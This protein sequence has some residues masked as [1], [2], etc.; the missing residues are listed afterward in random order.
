M[1][2][3]SWKI[4]PAQIFKVE[5]AVFTEVTS[6][7]VAALSSSAATCTGQLYGLEPKCQEFAHVERAGRT[8]EHNPLQ[9]QT[10][11]LIK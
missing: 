4:P 9:V 11:S 1:K 10:P 6:I 7:S 2:E 3:L 5:M 8:L